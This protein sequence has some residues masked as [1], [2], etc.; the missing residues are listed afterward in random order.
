MFV[1]NTTLK[2]TKASKIED[3][4]STAVF[5]EYKETTTNKIVVSLCFAL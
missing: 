2:P 5:H 1:D 4:L 3:F